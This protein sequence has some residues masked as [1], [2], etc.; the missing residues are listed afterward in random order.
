MNTLRVPSHALVAA[1]LIVA[2]QLAGAADEPAMTFETLAG[3]AK[4]RARKP[5]AD[6]RPA[7][8]PFWNELK[9]D[10]HREIE[11]RQD[12][13]LW[14]P[15]K[16]PFA[17]QFFHP[18][19]V[20]PRTVEIHEIVA[21]ATRAVPYRAEMFDYRKLVV[22]PGTPLPDGF[23]GWR[24]TIDLPGRG[25]SE[26]T[27]FLGASYFRAIGIDQTYGISARALCIDV[28]RP[29]G[30][31]FPTLVS[32]WLERPAPDA[33]T[34]RALALLDGP[35]VTGALRFDISPG[36]ETVTRLSGRLFARKPV[37][38][39]G[40][41]P[42][43]TMFWYGENTYPKPIDFRPEVHDSD[44]LLLE[45]KDGPVLWRPLENSRTIRHAVFE[46]ST[47]AGFGLAQRDRDFANYQD[48]E[49]HYHQRPS[50][51]VEPGE[52][53]PPGR[54]HLVE[55]P[56]GEETWDNVVAFWE[57]R[58]PLAAGAE[59]PFSY[60]IT[61]RD[62]I[63]VAGRAPVLASRRSHLEKTGE[64]LFVIEFDRDLAVTNELPSPVVRVGKGATLVD[65]R[66]MKNPVTGGHR[67]FFKLTAEPATKDLELSL[68]LE[69]GG[70]IVS[71]EWTYLW[72]RSE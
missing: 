20:F 9:Y 54:L 28:A 15:E 19:W 22:P 40:I 5:Y 18:G 33:R 11:F 39:L 60:T 4:E 30:E 2:S 21:S 6:D 72:R 64:D 8:A 10:E 37:A 43:S 62:A 52:Q 42:F 63:Y 47:L 26:F 27:S 34:L 51:W 13:A 53:W 70:K 17:V 44:G 1:L 69:R 58:E 25:P 57:P 31:E 38:L 35:S 71:E 41:A 59:L 3:M 56:T 55:L 14:L 12:Q 29:E 68:W 61:W 48:L 49:A 36:K 23:A 32:F 45:I 65:Q 7:L 67:A 46:V 24:A 50:V 16:L 66:V